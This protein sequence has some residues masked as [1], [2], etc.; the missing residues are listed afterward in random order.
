MVLKLLVCLGECGIFYFFSVHLYV[1]KNPQY[2]Y[3]F[4]KQDYGSTGKGFVKPL[5]TWQ[6]F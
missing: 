4:Y 1:T 5:G 6:L 3:P 2:P